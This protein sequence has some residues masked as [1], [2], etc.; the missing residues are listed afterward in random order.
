MDRHVVYLHVQ[1]V[2]QVHMLGTVDNPYVYY[3]HRAVA[4]IVRVKHV[5]NP[6]KPILN[7]VHLDPAKPFQRHHHH[8]HLL[9][10]LMS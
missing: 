10:R 6:V 4:S 8:H 3:V 7:G 2:L 9:I 5:V 1:N